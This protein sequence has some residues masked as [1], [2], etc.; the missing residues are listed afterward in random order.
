MLFSPRSSDIKDAEMALDS[1]IEQPLNRQISVNF[2]F[3]RGFSREE[4]GFHRSKQIGA[5]TRPHGFRFLNRG[6]DALSDSQANSMSTL[7]F[8]PI[9][10][11]V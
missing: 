7:T 4:H 5:L 8:Q 6:T 3:C 2:T 11:F 9:G 10:L 1:A